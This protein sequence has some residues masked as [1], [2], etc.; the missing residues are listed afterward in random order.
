MHPEVVSNKVGKCPKCGMKLTA[1]NK[2]QMKMKE[3]KT[4]A[5]P[6]HADITSAKPG[7]CS[8]C[9][10]DLVEKTPAAAGHQN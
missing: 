8:K 1:S 2:E 7:K 4:Y 10:M 6:M 9:N 3:M 5:C